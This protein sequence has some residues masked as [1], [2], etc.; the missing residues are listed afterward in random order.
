MA[1]GEAGPSSCRRWPAGLFDYN[2]QSAQQRPGAEQPSGERRQRAGRQTY[3]ARFVAPLRFWNCR[4]SF[5][6][7]YIFRVRKHSDRQSFLSRLFAH[8][9]ASCHPR[10]HTPAAPESRIPEPAPVEWSTPLR[11]HHNPRLHANQC[12]VLNAHLL[13]THPAPQVFPRLLLELAAPQRKKKKTLIQSRMTRFLHTRS[14][15]PCDAD[16]PK[17][18]TRQSSLKF[19]EDAP[20]LLT[21][22]RGPEVAAGLALERRCS[23][24][25]YRSYVSAFFFALLRQPSTRAVGAPQ[26]QETAGGE[27]FL[28]DMFREKCRLSRSGHV[29]V[30]QPARSLPTDTNAC[31]LGGRRRGERRSSGK[32]DPTACCPQR[33]HVVSDQSTAQSKDTAGRLPTVTTSPQEAAATVPAACSATPVTYAAAP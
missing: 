5:I 33:E 10:R 23:Q 24:R 13:D 6:S 12:T 31:V 16:R 2:R 3:S 8:L 17:A 26:H 29:H 9:G 1:A 32:A 28:V 30:C 15:H 27:H 19:V 14:S 11:P 4:C 18:L 7:A 21:G 20:R 25:S 22:L